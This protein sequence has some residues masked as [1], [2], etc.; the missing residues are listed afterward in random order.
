MKRTPLSLR[1]AA[2][3]R[4]TAALLAA[5]PVLCPLLCPAFWVPPASADEPPLC[6]DRPTRATVP[7]TVPEGRVQIESD[8]ALWTRT[9]ASGTRADSV[10]PLNPVVKLGLG[11]A[12]DIALNWA[13]YVHNRLREGDAV[14]R[15]EGVGDLTLRVK[16]R[17]T[18]ADAP[19][20]LALVP[21]IKAPTARTGIGNGAWEGGAVLSALTALPGK[22]TLAVVPEIDWLA[23]ADGS[24][25]HAQITGLVNLS[26]PLDPRLTLY[27]E[28]WAARNFDPAGTVRQ[29]SADIALAWL[30]RPRWQVDLGANIGLNRA[31][32]DAQL[33]LGLSTRF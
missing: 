15:Q 1:P 5:L 31:T 11:P 9:D 26:R 28:L 6:T 2:R 30:V 27:G 12:T 29:Y 7:C 17:L 25:R 4:R 20:Q 10:T 23:N 18:D 13:P 19:V 16:Q 21:W 14:R 32:P 24:G 3:P 22:L 8:L 33:S